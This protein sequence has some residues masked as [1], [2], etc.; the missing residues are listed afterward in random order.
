MDNKYDKL[1]KIILTGDSGVGKSNIL[2]KYINN[3]F[4]HESKSTIGVEFCTK[5]LFINDS[6]IKIQIWDTAG[7]ERFRAITKAYYRGSHG[8][9]MVYDVTSKKSF[10]NIEK[11][12]LESE[13]SLDDKCIIL[14]IGNKCDLINN[15]QVSY[16]EGLDFAIKK[17]F[18]FIE[19]SALNGD[20][21][22]TAFVSLVDN[23]AKNHND[24]FDNTNNEG[25]NFVSQ[26]L[27]LDRESDDHVIDRKKCCKL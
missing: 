3:E 13:E 26:I 5:T 14:L 17:K 10:N 22:E 12:I 2:S 16:K 1:F 9:I 20:N 25:G 7:Q 27:T 15:R 21:I 23:I 4:L 8:I 11:W 6:V 19:T 18:L 24:T